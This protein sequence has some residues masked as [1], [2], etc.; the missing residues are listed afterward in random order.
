LRDHEFLPKPL[1]VW[2]FGI[3]VFLY[4]TDK[5]PQAYQN[6]E[7]T[8]QEFAKI[9][10]NLDFNAAV[11]KEVVAASSEFET[12]LKRILTKD[13]AQRPTFADILDDQFFAGRVEE[14]FGLKGASTVAPEKKRLALERKSKS[15]M[16]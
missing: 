5:L 10:E 6:Q 9:V 14:T 8:Q 1:D 13:P 15:F 16:V 12:L 4:W 3:T 2:A 11:E 7:V